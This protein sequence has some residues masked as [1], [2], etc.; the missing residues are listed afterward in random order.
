MVLRLEFIRHLFGSG[1]LA[2]THFLNDALR[3]RSPDAESLALA[4]PYASCS[5]C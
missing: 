1:Q 4:P 5:Y 3:A 2:L